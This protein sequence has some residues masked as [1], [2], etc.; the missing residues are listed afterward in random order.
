LSSDGASTTLLKEDFFAVT[1]LVREP[2][3][4]AIVLKE[5]RTR[6]LASLRIRAVDRWLSR[7]ESRLYEVAAAVPG[8]PAFLGRPGP[9]TYAHHYVEGTTLDRHAGRV[10]DSFFADLERIIGGLH[11]LGMAYVDLG[12]DENVIVGED[13]RPYLIDFQIS[14]RLPRSKLARLL[15]GPIVRRLQAEDRYH[16][17]KQKQVYRPDLLTERNRE[18]LA[19]RSLLN[20]LHRAVVKPAYNVLVRHVLR[21]PRSRPGELHRGGAKHRGAVPG[22]KC[23]S[24]A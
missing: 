16:L 14:V 19:R 23:N 5:T 10:S 7:R 1:R 15:L 3:G 6:P 13:G 8:V 21:L 20:R 18:T 9:V 2:D 24:G 17:A 12:K 11:A 4:R 22:R